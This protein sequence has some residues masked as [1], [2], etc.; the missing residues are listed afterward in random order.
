M[1]DCTICGHTLDENQF[2]IPC[3]TAEAAIRHGQC[4]PDNHEML[5][6]E[7]GNAMRRHNWKRSQ[8]I[9]LRDLF[10]AY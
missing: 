9:K 10:P 3:D 6:Q 2:C 5:A 8:K 1:T 7:I 4:H